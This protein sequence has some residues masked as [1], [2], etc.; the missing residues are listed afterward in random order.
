VLKNNIVVLEMNNVVQEDKLKIHLKNIM[1]KIVKIQRILLNTKL[2]TNNNN[3][4]VKIKLD[5]PEN[6]LLFLQ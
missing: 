5:L 4:I 1:L 6:Y 2:Q 3:K